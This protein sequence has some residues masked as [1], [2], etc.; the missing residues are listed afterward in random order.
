MVH[1]QYIS[2]LI[3]LKLHRLCYLYLVMHKR[4]LLDF[5]KLLDALQVFDL[6]IIQVNNF[7]I[8]TELNIVINHLNI[9][10]LQVD[11][12][13]FSSNNVLLK[14]EGDLQNRV[15]SPNKRQMETLLFSWIFDCI[16]IGELLNERD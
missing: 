2:N 5:D 3:V 11:F 15:S 6:I 9:S 16:F 8:L 7:E 12:Y 13:S 4:K 1:I 10:S 14:M